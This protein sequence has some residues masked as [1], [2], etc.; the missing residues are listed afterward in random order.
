MQTV[1]H[2]VGPWLNYSA[3]HSNSTNSVDGPTVVLGKFW[4]CHCVRI[5]KYVKKHTLKFFP[6]LF[7]SGQL[8][9]SEI[10]CLIPN[11]GSEDEVPV[12][13][14][15]TLILPRSAHPPVILS[16]HHFV[17]KTTFIP[18]FHH[19]FHVFIIKKSFSWGL[20]LRTSSPVALLC[21]VIFAFGQPTQQPFPSTP[22]NKHPWTSMNDWRIIG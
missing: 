13:I 19:Y 8:F 9:G 14:V 22:A 2:I 12:C 21:G 11:L 3:G 15:P 10:P 18:C 20:H 17:N 5:V 16:W 6:R 4:R 1:Q 7:W